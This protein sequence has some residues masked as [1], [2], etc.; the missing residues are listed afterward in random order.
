MC[1]RIFGGWVCR[2]AALLFAA[3]AT[4]G[5]LRAQVCLDKD[6]CNPANLNGIL[7]VDGARHESLASA[8]DACPQTCWIIDTFPETLSSN[9]FAKIAAKSV[10]V[11]LGRGTWVTKVPIVI[12]TKS[13]LEGSGRGDPGFSGTVIQADSSFP[14]VAAVIEMGNAA[15]SMGVR[16]E[17]LTIDC[18]N[19]AGC[20]GLQNVRSQEQSGARHLLIE[21]IT[22]IG[23]DVEGSAAQNSGPFEDLEFY[24][25]T[26]FRTTT[27][28]QCARIVNVP[29]FRGIHGATCNFN[30]YFVHPFIGIQMDSTGTLNDI[31]LEGVD[32]GI[33]VGVAV[34]GTGAML[35]N[36]YGGGSNIQTLVRVFSGREILLA[37]LVR[38]T[39]PVL[40]SHNGRNLRN[41]NLAVYVVHNA[42]R[43]LAPATIA[44]M[45]AASAGVP[46][47]APPERP[48]R[49]G[50]QSFV[51]SPEMM[52][53]IS[54]TAI[55]D[56]HGEADVKL[57][58]AFEAAGSEFRYQLTP[59]GDS[60]SVYVAREIGGNSFRIAGGKPGQR[61]SWQV[62]AIQRE[63]ES[64]SPNML[65][66]GGSQT[67][68]Q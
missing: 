65:I 52:N 16:V 15:T 19:V 60:A 7:F 39:T 51:E 68:P 66:R 48:N 62:T 55:L 59:I 58:D 8:I 9:P 49:Y 64:D 4:G 1:N 67:E 23:L 47:S 22:G 26:D 11:T 46:V 57:P 31:H 38:A 5:I 29:A 32:I 53:V 12:P 63:P 56:A 44:N 13:Q 17:N 2:I 40:L 3:F 42:G 37:G 43:P 25:G 18:N 33:G 36:I 41:A 14:P 50:A 10:K 28:S 6:A 24:G 35:Q 30:N 34:P 61:I 21:N 45:A 54:G 20:I 27:A